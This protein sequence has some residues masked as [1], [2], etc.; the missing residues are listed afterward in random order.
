MVRNA[1][2]RPDARDELRVLPTRYWARGHRRNEFVWMRVLSPS[3][4]LLGRYKGGGIDWAGFAAEYVAQM[5]S[6]SSA[7]AAV[8]KLHGVAA[9][10]ERTV[11]LYCHEEPGRPCHR[12]I[13]CEMVVAGRIASLAAA[14][15]R[16]EDGWADDGMEPRP[17]CGR[18]GGRRR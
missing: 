15:T 7:R 17:R 6:D 16:F 18:G 9:S 1:R 10:G 4:D 14:C 5:A 12:H 11:A 2:G 13:L 8:G 3:A